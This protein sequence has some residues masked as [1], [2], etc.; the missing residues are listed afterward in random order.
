MLL[1]HNSALIRPAHLR[2]LDTATHGSR[3][4]RWVEHCRLA[5]GCLMH[6]SPKER[7]LWRKQEN[8]VAVQA[9]SKQR[10]PG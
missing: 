2:R 8:R 5:R 6:L 4:L 10:K 1:G 3:G 9:A 7:V